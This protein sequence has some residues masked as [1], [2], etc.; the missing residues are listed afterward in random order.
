VITC[1]L[2]DNDFDARARPMRMLVK[3]CDSLHKAIGSPNFHSHTDG[4]KCILSVDFRPWQRRIGSA[5]NESN[6]NKIR[7]CHKR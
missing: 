7:L 2:L 3:L 5:E 1:K 4:K 6:A